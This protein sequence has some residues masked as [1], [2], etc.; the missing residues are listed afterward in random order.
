MAASLQFRT[1][2][3]LDDAPD[4]GCRWE[5]IDG[6]LLVSPGPDVTH[7]LIVSSLVARIFAYLESSGAADVLT[8]PSDVRLDQ[9]TRMQP[10]VFV[11]RWPGA[12]VQASPLSFRDVLL[13]IE[14][15]SP[16]SASTDRVERRIA[17]MNAG[18]PEY[19]IVDPVMRHIERWRPGY[20]AAEIITDVI[21][22]HLDGLGSTLHIDLPSL[23]ARAFRD[24]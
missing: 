4:D 12:G 7:Q 11:I 14:V 20:L 6:H 13:T 18:V 9:H 5:L 17:Y 8:S 16:S 15:V 2:D 3:D 24:P 23:F 21:S 22:F 19:W 10:D 1:A